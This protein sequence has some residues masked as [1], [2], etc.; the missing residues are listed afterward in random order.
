MSLGLEIETEAETV[1]E[2]K[3]ATQFEKAA[4]RLMKERM[5]IAR[6]E[7]GFYSVENS[8]KG[9]TYPPACLP[10]LLLWRDVRNAAISMSLTAGTWLGRYE[11]FLGVAYAQAGEHERA[12]TILRRL[13]TSNE[14][15]SPGE[16]AV[17]YG[18]LCERERAFASLERAYAEHDLQLQ[19]LKADPAF[20]PLRSDPRF[21]DLMR[22]VGLPQYLTI[23]P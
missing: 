3:A 9:R 5:R 23:H 11:I 15:V 8:T 2:I 4:A 18:A 16:L 10:A 21:T 12:R 14:Y 22:R 20:D 6:H 13:E 17:L 1:I 7:P 19:F